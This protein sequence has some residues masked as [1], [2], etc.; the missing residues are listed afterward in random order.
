LQDANYN[1]I[2]LVNNA[3][4]LVERYEY[5]PYGQRTVYSRGFLMTDVNDDGADLALWQQDTGKSLAN[6]ELV[7]YATLESSRGKTSA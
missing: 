5:T 7:T 3:G 6:D 2:G 1:V 4:G